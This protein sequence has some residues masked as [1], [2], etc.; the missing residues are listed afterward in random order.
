MGPE[1][2]TDVSIN[3]PVVP[4]ADLAPS[5]PLWIGR[6]EPPRE[7]NNTGSI[8]SLR[9][10]RWRQSIF[11]KR[12]K[13]ST[14]SLCQVHLLFWIARKKNIIEFT[15]TG[16]T[17]SDIEDGGSVYYRNVGNSVHI[18]TV[19]SPSPLLNSP[20]KN[21]IEFTN[22]GS[23][24]FDIEDGAENT[25]ETSATVSTSSLCQVHLLF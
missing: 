5:T 23:T 24:Y 12:R 22:T 14:S 13:L 1:V 11:P 21:T 18:L 3:F 10:R 16:S 9:H 15:N 2:R 4:N 8:C 6:K 7:F 17:Y 19:P 20:K 25:P